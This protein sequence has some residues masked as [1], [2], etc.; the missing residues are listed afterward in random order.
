M[1]GNPVD[2]PHY[3]E[4][5]SPFEGLLQ[6]QGYAATVLTVRGADGAV[7]DHVGGMDPLAALAAGPDL[8]TMLRDAPTAAVPGEQYVGAGAWVDV[9]TRSVAFWGRRRGPDLG[10]LAARWPGWHLTE[11]HDGLP[12]QLRLSGRDG[13]PVQ[14]P[15]RV[16]L[17]E[18]CAMFQPAGADGE[19]AHQGLLLE[20][21]DW[22]GRRG[23]TDPEIAILRR[24]SR[25]GP[26]EPRALST[27]RDPPPHP[28]RLE[29]PR[30]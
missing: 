2:L 18:A 4:I 27:P 3:L 10:E 19:Q 5:A 14:L 1:L 21:P 15:W 20:G 30:R 26:V 7:R 22:P 8:V 6:L 28:E 12:E 25:D 23:L 24:L 11:H 16:V 13:A 29:A 17:A 9:T